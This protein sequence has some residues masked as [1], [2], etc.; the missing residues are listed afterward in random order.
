M[1]EEIT[2]VFFDLDH[3]LWD[4]EKNSAITFQNI[5]QEAEINVDLPNFLEA[6]VP[7]NFSY[8]KLFREEK[9]SKEE[10]RY[11]RLKDTFDALSYTIND[12]QINDLSSKY[13]EHLSNQKH[14]F[15][16]ANVILN[17][18]KPKYN[19]HII[20]NGFEEV[21]EKKMINANIHNFFTHIINSE[22]VGVKKP[23][24]LIFEYALNKAGIEA[25]FAVMIGDD[26]EADIIGAKAAG[27]YAIH[28]NSNNEEAHEH[29]ITINNLIEIKEYL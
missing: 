26:L 1:K 6:Y 11:K 4:F 12:D 7:L 22:M 20:T 29:A 5:L 16:N 17:Y 14:V 21:Q 10:L 23:N 2:D 9:V 15:E 27:M 28:F 25:R 13:I 8:W 24:P 3:T 18:L 19:L